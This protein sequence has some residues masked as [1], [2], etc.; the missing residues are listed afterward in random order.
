[1]CLL[2]KVRLKGPSKTLSYVRWGGLAT[3][4]C[5]QMISCHHHLQQPALLVHLSPCLSIHL[6]THPLVH[7]STHLLASSSPASIHLHII[8]FFLPFIQPL[9]HP[10]IHFNHSSI[11]NPPIYSPIHPSFS[12]PL[13]THSSPIYLI[14]YII[15]PFNILPPHVHPI[16]IQPSTYSF[17]LPALTHFWLNYSSTRSH[18]HHPLIY[19]PIIYLLIY[20]TL[21]HLFANPLLHP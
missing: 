12:L 15:N 14:I 7:L 2:V 9:T 17:T 1:M 10:T 4:I 13:I 3:L 16:F 18:T 20:S 19:P 6:S 5:I 8:D 21:V 11:I